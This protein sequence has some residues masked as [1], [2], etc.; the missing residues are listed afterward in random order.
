MVL[1]ALGEREQPGEM[2]AEEKAQARRQAFG[3]WW[4]SIL[5]GILATAL[6]W[7]LVR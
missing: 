4:K 7:T 6:I 1:A 2:T 5:A 3:V